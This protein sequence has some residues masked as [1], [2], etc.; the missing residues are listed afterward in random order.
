ME[1]PCIKVCRLRDGKCEGCGRTQEQLRMWT[2]YTDQQRKQIME[3]I[4]S[5][6]AKAEATDTTSKDKA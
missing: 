2:T 1:T 6:T 4:S 3:D 5:G